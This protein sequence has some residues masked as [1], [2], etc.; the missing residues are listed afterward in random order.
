VAIT[1]HTEKEDT[2][3]VEPET[4]S[5]TAEMALS[6][7]SP[8]EVDT[9]YVS[10]V[11]S[12]TF[13][14]FQQNGYHDE[15]DDIDF[16]PQNGYLEP[17]DMD[18]QVNEGAGKGKKAGAP[19]VNLMGKIGSA[20]KNARMPTPGEMKE[21]YL[22][23]NFHKSLHQPLV[24]KTKVEKIDVQKAR[25]AI[26]QEKTPSQLGNIESISDIPVPIIR[27]SKGDKI[28]T[29]EEGPGMTMPRNM[30]EFGQAAYNTLPRSFREQNII[31]AVKENLDPEE[32]ERNQTL[33]KTKTPAELAQIHSLAEFPVP[34]RIKNLL[35]FE[36]KETEKKETKK[37]RHSDCEPEIA[38]PFTM[39]ST[40]PR[41]LRETK[42]VT[43]VKVQEDDEVL[44]SRQALVESRSPLE[45]SAIT[46]LSDLP[47]PS[48][49]TRMMNRTPAAASTP[50]SK[51]DVSSKS[52]SKG[53]SKVNVND[54]FSTLPK[55][56]T[57]ELSVKTK[58]NK[59]QDEVER[60]KKLIGEKSPTELGNIGSISDL[61]IPSALQNI[62]TRSDAPNA[63]AKPEKPKRKNIEE[64]RK[65]NLTTGTFL[66]P[67][68]L[69]ES[70]RETKLLVR[71][72]V[73]EDDSV[74]KSRQELIESKTPAELGQIN[75]LSDLPVPTRIQTLMR[76]K[77]R[78]LKS[79]E[80]KEMSK[81]VSG[82][83]KS[84]PAMTE[85]MSIPSS[86]NSQLLVKSKVEDPEIVTRNKEIIKNKS[87]SELSQIRD[88]S[89]I[90][91]PAGIENFFKQNPVKNNVERN[92]KMSDSTSERPTSPQSFKESIYE[93]LPRSLRDK[94]LL[95]KSKVDVDEEKVRER[96]EI[97]RT[98]SPADLSQISS[99]SDFPIPAPVENLLKKKSEPGSPI[100][101][102]RKWKKEDI[103]ESMPSS[104]TC[105]L[106]VRS[107]EMA[108]PEELEHRKELIRTQTPAQLSE[109][110]SLAEFPV[111]KFLGN[112]VSKTEPLEKKTG[113]EEAE[114]E[115]F[116]I[117]KL[118]PAS[119]MD[120]KLLVK[121]L[122]EDPEVQA[123]RAEIVKSKSVVELSQIASFSDIP[124]PD[125]IE[126]FVKK[127]YAP[128]ERKKKFK[129]KTKSQ[130]TQSLSQSMYS[131][132]PRSLKKDLLVKSCIEDPDV[133]AEH[134]AI[135]ASKSVSE[136][137]QITSLSDIPI[138]AN[139]SRVFHKSME[140]LSGL[141]TPK[142]DEADDI[143]PITPGSRSIT[144][145]I[146]A[147]LPKSL[148]NELIVK[149]CFEDPEVQQERKAI[150][151]SK[152]VSE[153]SQ[154]KSLSDIPIPENI[155]KL[156]SRTATNKTETPEQQSID[157]RPVSRGSRSVAGFKEDM[158]AS[159]PRSLKD[160][161]I[162]RTKVEE[163]D[164]VLS[165]R[166]ALV[167]S[168]SP[169]E[170]SEIHSLGELPIPSRIEAWLHGSNPDAQRSSSAMDES[171]MTLPRTKKEFQ[172]AMYR[173][174]PQSLTQP[175]VVRS[176]VE[177]PNILIERQQLQQTKSIHEL[178]K[179]RNLNELPIPG[180]LVK[181]PDVPLPRIRSILNYIA[182]P[183]PRTPRTPKGTKSET[184]HSY[185]SAQSETVESTPLTEDK[186][187]HSLSNGNES[188]T[189]SLSELGY[190]M[191]S[192][193]VTPEAPQIVAT[194][195][196]Q[197][198]AVPQKEE[199]MPTPPPP[200]EEE[201][202]FSLAD[203]IK[204]TPERSMRNK[205]KKNRRSHEVHDD[206]M[207]VDGSVVSESITSEE[208]PPPLPPKR[209]TPSP[210]IESQPSMEEEELEAIPVKGILTLE[211]VDG[212]IQVVR[213]EVQVPHVPGWNEKN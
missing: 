172:E 64:K 173:T 166:Q 70:W 165:Q 65:R 187:L 4:V 144:E 76:S 13:N 197:F 199:R 147:T 33:T 102:P 22:N 52:S 181:L 95:V 175:C 123:V 84:L 85:F 88:V 193:P 94:Q 151:E 17:E 126:N 155:E 72:K 184:Y 50:S 148:K 32:L 189:A 31:T 170:L 135:V 142:T 191:I 177:D 24:V 37:R 128:A 153:L 106:V 87:V 36:K 143:R 100:A 61:P 45:L 99:F 204:G 124:I 68:F 203:Q 178:S 77:K 3:G 107:R 11:S 138:P 83:A 21:G 78:V 71:S 110:H 92:E 47:I 136:L 8:G 194:P 55:V 89:D 108:D 69:P 42:L 118:Y 140:R 159:L 145:N 129:E 57:M 120:K 101:P 62:F 195:P 86:L 60:R 168:K 190:E 93:T 131:T 7:K 30:E 105:E 139:L 198:K 205:K 9:K 182:K 51:L 160:Q 48:K 27:K 125:A 19:K 158:Y 188:P 54:M 49:I 80:E 179:I 20:I 104:L 183:A 146:Y 141:K 167:E 56:L 28:E 5:T 121:T 169:A 185:E 156:I 23:S 206:M 162:V 14:T 40:L 67:D 115:P 43:N 212:S 150:T 207:S 53:M 46:S 163:N 208:I 112:L 113:E 98:K 18:A 103:Y 209:V 127:S 149:S 122:T 82:S 6:A 174:L 211:A 25:Q 213:N 130:S 16:T 10:V 97:T 114:K 73:V 176:T 186:M 196:E 192:K 152:S 26:T 96:Q 154:I 44:K 180:N 171:P 133:L 109:I 116:S 2:P 39:Y 134:R 66:S 38:E 90:P 81:K 74:L 75:G 157:S 34:D 117:E 119:L 12:D 35:V 1:S 164:E 79:T 41:S 200:E 201:D 202:H 63:A 111:P 210:K 91:I 137:S 132:L 58:I 15:E 161:L 59:D 29:E